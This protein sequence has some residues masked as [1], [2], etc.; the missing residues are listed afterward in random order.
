MF[1]I[2]DQ[3]AVLDD[4]I[5]G[6]VIRIEGA[7]I[8]IED[9]DGFEMSFDESEIVKIAKDNLLYHTPKNLNQI[10][11]EKEQ[12]KKRTPTLRAKKQRYQPPMEVDLHIDKLIKSYKRL[13]N[14]EILNIQLETA[15]RQLAFAVRKRIQRII[16]IHG[17]GAGVLKTELEY[18]LS[19]YDGIKII[20]ADYKKYG[21]GAMEVYIP[22]NVTD[23]E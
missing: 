18:L 8:I 21:L 23:L 13:S 9:T 12:P 7:T 17:V 10:L 2:G 14:Y 11:K 19:G 5:N 1:T 4:D 6:V 15:K 22:Q 16:F 3:I 20:E